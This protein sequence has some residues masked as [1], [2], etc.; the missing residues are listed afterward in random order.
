LL[1]DAIMNPPITWKGEGFCCDSLE[2][3]FTEFTY[4]MEGH[5]EVKLIY[6]YGGASLGTM[7]DGNRWIEMYQ[8]PKLDMVVTQDCWWVSETG[9]A[10]VI[11]PACTNLERNDIGE[12]GEAGG[13]LKYN[14]NGANYRVIVHQRKAIEPYGESRSDYWI[15]AELAKR[16]G[17]YDVF[18]DGG[19][20]EEDWIRAYF[21]ISDLPKYISWE[22]FEKRGYYVI[23][24]QDDY[25]PTPS[26]RWFYEG[27]PVDT[28]DAMNPKRGTDKAHEL[29]T[30]SGKIEFESQDLLQHTPDDDERPPVPRYIPSWE[31]HESELAKKYPLQMIT[32]HPRYSFH[33][34]YDK[35]GSWVHEVPGHRRIIDGYAYQTVRINPKDAA[36]RG[37]Q[38]G[39]IVKLF[40]DR[41]T[42]LGWAMVTER[43]MPGSI[44]SY[45]SSAQYA[46][47][48]KGKAYTPDRGGCVNLLTPGRLMSKNAPGMAPNS[49]LIEIAKWEA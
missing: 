17:V 32:P 47:L 49:C 31:G 20:T 19:K 24:L 28:P 16:L 10:D 33:T 42:V 43:I 4:P 35:T 5:S 15:F 36:A 11:L 38:N 30:Y 45:C 14:S 21:D 29:G 25:E 12:W 3:Q 44:H 26:L 46:P 41:A 1:P 6:R 18:S 2:Q 7:T 37:I 23:P 22:E 39:D 27:R 9:F 34:H 8:N 48:E 13:Y 40:N